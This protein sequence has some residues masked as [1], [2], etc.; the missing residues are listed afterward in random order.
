MENVKIMP[1]ERGR[2]WLPVKCGSDIVKFA[3]P[4]VK[5]THGECFEAIAKDKELKPAEGIE[6]ALLAYSAYT[7][8]DEWASV[9][10][11]CFRANYVRTPN[12]ILWIPKGFIKKVK[13]LSGVLVER[14][15]DGKGL[16]TKMKVPSDFSSWK[17]KDGLYINKGLT[18]VPK[19]KYNFG[20][21]TE[22]D[23]FA[24]A[25]L[26]EEGV[27]IFIKIAKDAKL[28]PYNFGINVAEINEPAQRVALL[29]GLSGRLDLNGYDWDDDTNCRAFGVRD[30]KADARKN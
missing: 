9:K 2:T 19:D 25:I 5:G 23:G 10:Q 28:V 21:M 29:G 18:F 4:P 22:K 6:L 16:S 12:R 15:L 26:S 17:E 14:D 27:P 8:K 11:D 30:G 1:A 24:R 7:G 13:S 20:E 3:Y